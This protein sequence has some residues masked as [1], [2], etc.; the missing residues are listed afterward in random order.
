MFSNTLTQLPLNK[1]VKFLEK[2]KGMIINDKIQSFLDKLYTN[3]NKTLDNLIDLKEGTPEEVSNW[4]KENHDL[5]I[6]LNNDGDYCIATILDLILK[7]QCPAE[8]S[9]FSIGNETFLSG[10]HDDDNV[11]CFS[12]KKDKN[13]NLYQVLMENR[14]FEFFFSDSTPSTHNAFHLFNNLDILNDEKFDDNFVLNDANVILYRP[15][16]NIYE[17]VNL[18]PVFNGVKFK[19]DMELSGIETITSVN[20]PLDQV[21]IKQAAIAY[22]V[23]SSAT[24]LNLNQKIVRITDDFTFF[25]KY[26]GQL[27]FSAVVKKD[28]FIKKEEK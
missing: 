2:E 19:T 21:K 26:K 8:E 13:I 23:C 27:V 16:A 4:L 10:M 1:L 7:F 18:M 25:V 12:L 24:P 6:D 22:V 14:D 15:L 20:L 17:R 9:K 3:S 11:E 5:D 28:D